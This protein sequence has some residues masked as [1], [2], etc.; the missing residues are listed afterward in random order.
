MPSNP[1]IKMAEKARYGLALGS[2]QRN[3]IRLAP[4][5]AEYMGIRT[6]AERLLRE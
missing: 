4:G 2:G 3:S 6:A 1:A 5:A